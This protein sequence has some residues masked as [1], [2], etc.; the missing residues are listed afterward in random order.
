MNGL[1]LFCLA[2]K[3]YWRGVWCTPPKLWGIYCEGK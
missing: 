3:G 2:K 1:R